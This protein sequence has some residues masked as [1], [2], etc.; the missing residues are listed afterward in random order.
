MNGHD[1]SAERGKGNGRT[2]PM[3]PDWAL[4]AEFAPGE[5]GAFSPQLEGRTPENEENDLT[6]EPAFELLDDPRAEALALLHETQQD[7]AD[8]PFDEAA[9]PHEPAEQV[10]DETIEQLQEQILALVVMAREIESKLRRISEGRRTSNVQ[11]TSKV[12][13]TS[14]VEPKTSGSMAGVERSE[15]AAAPFL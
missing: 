10:D 1:L 3:P 6:G 2:S 8:E 9:E 12:Q 11:R 5:N 4:G 13:R 7:R 14:N 15:A